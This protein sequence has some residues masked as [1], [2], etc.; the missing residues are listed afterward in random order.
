MKTQRVLRKI[1]R[2]LI[3]EER[4]ALE[5]RRDDLN[6][7]EEV[8]EVRRFSKGGEDR[9]LTLKEAYDRAVWKVGKVEAEDGKHKE[10][11]LLSQ[12]LNRDF[13]DYSPH[14]YVSSD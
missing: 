11:N 14:N 10:G 3:E 4:K 6:K 12:I 1:K 8:N 2:R 13:G 5:E 7:K 9:A